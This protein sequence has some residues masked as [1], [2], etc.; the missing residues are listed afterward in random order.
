[1]FKNFIVEILHATKLLKT[2]DIEIENGMSVGSM[3]AGSATVKNDLSV[4]GNATMEKDLTVKEDLSVKGNATME[5]DL[6]VKEDLSVKGNATMEK[7]LTVKGNVTVN[8]DLEV[9]EDLS[10]D[11]KSTFDDDVTINGNVAMKELKVDKIV[12]NGKTY[13]DSSEIKELTAN[14]PLNKNWGGDISKPARV[15]HT[16]KI[17]NAIKNPY[18]LIIRSISSSIKIVDYDGSDEKEITINYDDVGAAKKNHA[19]TSNEFGVGNDTSYGHVKL[20]NDKNSTS[21]AS[22]GIATSPK[23]VR[24][25]INAKVTDYLPLIGG[26]MTGAII[27][28]ANAVG[29]SIGNKTEL[30]DDNNIGLVIKSKQNSYT[31]VGIG[32]DN[33]TV[34]TSRP[35]DGTI[36]LKNLNTS[37]SE[38]AHI[39]ER[40]IIDHIVERV[41]VGTDSWVPERSG[42]YRIYIVGGGGNGASGVHKAVTVRDGSLR[43]DNDSYDG[44]SASHYDI[45]AEGNG[46][47][48]P[49]YGGG[50][51]GV[52][53]IDVYVDPSLPPYKIK[54][55]TNDDGDDVET[56]SPERRRA[57]FTFDGKKITVTGIDSVSGGE[58]YD[59]DKTTISVYGGSN[60]TAGS[61]SLDTSG[62][63]IKAYSWYKDNSDGTYSKHADY[64]N[65]IASIQIETGETDVQGLAPNTKPSNI[66]SLFGS[67]REWKTYKSK[68]GIKCCDDHVY[69][70]QN[71]K[72]KRYNLAGVYMN[73]YDLDYTKMAMHISGCDTTSELK[74][75]LDGQ[76][77][78]SY[79]K[80][81]IEDIP[82]LKVVSGK[83]VE[84][85]NNQSTFTS[86]IAKITYGSC[87][88]GGYAEGMSYNTDIYDYF[89]GYG[90]DSDSIAEDIWSEL[91]N[92]CAATQQP[93]R[94]FGYGGGIPGGINCLGIV[95]GGGAAGGVK[96]VIPKANVDGTNEASSKDGIRSGTGASIFIS[97]LGGYCGINDSS[98][99][100]NAEA[101]GAGYYGGGGGGG[102]AMVYNSGT[103]AKGVKTDGGTGGK[104]C[105]IIAYLGGGM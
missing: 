32:S 105:V 1:M 57:T 23:V 101:G 31:L 67:I 55:T 94:S 19:S 85:R 45:E 39:P 63:S 21:D 72:W 26:T 60:A 47:T 91:S 15:N 98:L 40:A 90:D 71:S 9:K 36:Y 11:G 66:N 69:L 51:G 79:V 96:Y 93:R 97:E 62:D 34:L 87:G 46:F 44:S 84:Y 83:Y 7:D 25:M 10:V 13:G 29:I 14:S 41:I 53:V 16:H 3:E 88:V 38:F 74:E 104:P 2:K 54:T 4:K 30:A 102:S 86:H 37:Y 8:K 80:E 49:G 35:G 18:S 27:T 76:T 100:P 78:S 64:T 95:G 28:P 61:I 73:G 17:P 48:L 52:C 56:L 5:K 92:D 50:G 58:F 22:S 59:E 103:S 81:N 12:D 89:G 43:T 20:T 75:F 70:Y 68:Q 77:I 99:T 24:D 6:T 82:E 65:R 33:S 42:N